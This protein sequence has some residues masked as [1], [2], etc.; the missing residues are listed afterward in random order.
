[1]KKLIWLLLTLLIALPQTI[2]VAGQ[3]VGWG[4]NVDG[5]ATPPAGLSNVIAVAA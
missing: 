3:V 4:R 2:L 1:M 5:Q